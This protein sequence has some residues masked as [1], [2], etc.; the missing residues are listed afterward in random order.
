MAERGIEM[1]W[2]E[3]TLDAPERVEADPG[4]P[5][6][7]RAFGAIPERDGRILRVVYR[8]AGGAAFVVTAFF[9]RGARR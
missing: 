6:L 3:R 9:D 7:L 5:S 1:S 8:P 4:D 2:V